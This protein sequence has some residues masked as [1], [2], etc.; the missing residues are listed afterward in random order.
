MITDPLAVFTN[1]LSPIHLQELAEADAQ[2]EQ[3][4]GVHVS[5]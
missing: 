3:I 5:D 2:M 4:Q 1:L